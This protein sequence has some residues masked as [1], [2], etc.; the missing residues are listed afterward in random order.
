MKSAT[1]INEGNNTVVLE[2]QNDVN[3]QEILPKDFPMQ[4]NIVHFP[5]PLN[6]ECTPTVALEKELANLF[7]SG[8]LQT[9]HAHHFGP[10]GVDIDKLTKYLFER[11]LFDALPKRDMMVDE[12]IEPY[13]MKIALNKYMANFKTLWSNKFRYT[14]LL[15]R[16]ITVLLRIYLAPKLE[17]LKREKKSKQPS[18]SFFFKFENP[19]KVK[20]E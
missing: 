3:V 12:S 7:K 11:V 13:L 17:R 9:I 16:V 15:N 4:G 20:S 10:R 19:F 2:E 5:P 14:R 18:K 6:K 1:F 8:H